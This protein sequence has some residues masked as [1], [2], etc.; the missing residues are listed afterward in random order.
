M[1]CRP[2]GL[3]RLALICLWLAAGLGGLA[4]AAASTSQMLE[5]IATARSQL[6]EPDREFLDQAA[7]LLSEAELE[8]FLALEEDY[9]RQAFVEQFWR[10]HDPF[11]ETPRNELRENLEA[12]LVAA[13]ERFGTA[14]DSRRLYLILHGPPERSFRVGCE[15]LRSLEIWHYRSSPIVRGEF[16]L[17]FVRQGGDWRLWSPEEGLFPLLLGAASLD[18]QSTADE[19]SDECT[20]GDRILEALALSFD[21]RRLVAESPLLRGADPEWARDFLASGTTLPEDAAELPGSVAVDYPGRYQSRTVVQLLVDLGDVEIE[22]DARRFVVD[23]EV[24]RGDQLFE[25]FRYRFDSPETGPQP[26]LVLQRYLRPG[27]YEVVLRV[28]EVPTERYFRERLTL[29][30]PAV[31]RP[32]REVHSELALSEEEGTASA[33]R[34]PDLS[35]ANAVIETTPVLDAGEE[36]AR[37][38]VV[39]QAPTDR[40]ILGRVRVEAE[41]TGPEVARVA[42]S[43]DDRPV[44]S[45]ASPPYSVDLDVGRSPQ[46]HRLRAEALDADG[47]VL[48]DDELQLNLGPHRFAVRLVEPIRGRSYRRSVRAVAEVEVPEQE[49]LDRLEFYLND[50]L[51]ATVY[52]PPFVQPILVP[53]QEAVAYVRVLGFLESGASAEDVVFVNAPDLVDSIDVNMVELYTTVVDRRGEIRTDLGPEDFRIFEDGAAMTLRRFERVDDVPIHACILL[54]TSISMETRLR[55]A[56]AA[57]LHFFQQVVEDDDRACLF[58]FNDSSELVVPFTGD[59]EILAGGLS[60]LIAEGETALFDS[61]IDGLYYF[62]GLKGKRALILLTDGEDSSSEFDFDEALEYARRAGVAIYAVGL[63]I[64]SRAVESRHHLQ[65]LSRETGGDTVYVDSTLGLKRIYSQIERELRSQYLLTYEST[66]S[67]RQ[68]EFREIEV[69]VLERGL[70]AKTMRG[71]YP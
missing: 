33:S 19:I 59:V 70:E 62:G 8:V 11:P 39:L 9:R 52:Q 29:E 12:G 69:E 65:R 58:T 21:H 20:A 60:E 24:L 37:H 42:F 44:L 7:L 4:G 41:V 13:D 22:N 49:R 6:S 14:L 40:L 64:P 16:Y 27:A 63:A 10:T 55:E 32:R 53:E 50:T 45:K 36:P 68:G 18:L 66:S 1:T 46:L 2:L 5:R 48:A 31:T 23:G 67:D 57:A 61:L 71:Y 51:V 43:V 35:E 25:S 28:R 15:L 34:T 26:P 30:V 47:N 54:D 56:V 38:R 3:P 17:V